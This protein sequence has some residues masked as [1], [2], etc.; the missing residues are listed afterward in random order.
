M[1]KKSLQ[2]NNI[3]FCFVHAMKVSGVQKKNAQDEKG[4][5]GLSWSPRPAKLNWL[6]GWLAGLPVWAA[7]TWPKPL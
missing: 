3:F 6:A 7:E 5:A 4:F 2:K 1:L